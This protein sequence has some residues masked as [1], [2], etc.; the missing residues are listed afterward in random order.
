MTLTSAIPVLR[1]GDYPAAR[2]FW[3]E[4]MGFAIAEEGGDR[5]QFGIFKRDAAVVFVDA[6]HGPDAAPSPGWRAYFHNDD[7][8]ALAQALAASGVSVAG[9]VDTVYGMREIVV[10]D[11]AGNRLCFGQDT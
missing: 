10:E 8:D 11:L 7:V 5:A 1:V 2:A 3:T 4:I 6:W 9:P